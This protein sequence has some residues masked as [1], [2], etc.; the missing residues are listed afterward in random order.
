M[1]TN[2]DKL[3]DILNSMSDF[4]MTRILNDNQDRLLIDGI[5]VI[6]FKTPE[7]IVEIGNQH[8]SFTDFKDCVRFVCS[9]IFLIKVVEPILGRLK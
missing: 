7:Y 2:L 4:D 3:R 8:K 6:E 9:S 1:I 5:M